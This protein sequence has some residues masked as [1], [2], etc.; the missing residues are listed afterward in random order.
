M[1]AHTGVH[2]I[3]IYIFQRKIVSMWH[4][5]N[6]WLFLAALSCHQQQQHILLS[7]SKSHFTA[8]FCFSSLADGM[9]W[10]RNGREFPQPL[11]FLRYFCSSLSPSA[12]SKSCQSPEA[13]FQPSRMILCCFNGRRSFF[14]HKKGFY[15]A[16]SNKL[17]LFSTAAEKKIPHNFNPFTL[18]TN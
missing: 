17:E 6:F 2:K 5:L 15:Q 18:T 3:Y 8:N 7:T 1:V 12:R 14:A 10:I 16:L 9:R 11:N 13:N 4:M